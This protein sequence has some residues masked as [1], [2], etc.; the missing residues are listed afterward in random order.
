MWSNTDRQTRTP[1]TDYE[2]WRHRRQE[3]RSNPRRSA[4]SLPP[5]FLQWG[6]RKRLL[7]GEDALH[8]SLALQPVQYKLH[9]EFK[10]DGS[11]LF[12]WHRT[13]QWKSL[14]WALLYRGDEG[15]STGPQTV[16]R[17]HYCTSFTVIMAVVYTNLFLVLKSDVN[18]QFNL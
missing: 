8:A 17:T 15:K 7:E 13:T 4:E 12:E 10:S 11:H 18:I 14:R 9:S 1:R 3:R 2:S 16:C 5:L 6:T